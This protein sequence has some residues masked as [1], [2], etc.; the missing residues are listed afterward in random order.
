VKR[1]YPADGRPYLPLSEQALS[2]LERLPREGE[3]LFPGRT[4]ARL[5]DLKGPSAKVCEIAGPAGS[6]H[7]RLASLVRVPLGF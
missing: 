1:S 5:T 2:L 3:Y 6:A 7:P 4:G